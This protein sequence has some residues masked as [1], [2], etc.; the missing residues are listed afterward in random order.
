MDWRIAPSPSFC[1]HRASRSRW[2]GSTSFFNSLKIERV[3]GTRYD[4][5]AAAQA[6]L[7]DYIEPFYNR[8]RRHSTL[9]Y[10]SPTQFMNDW[11]SAQH[12]KKQ[13]A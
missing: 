10:R 8:R 11:I 4:A 1:R 7:F 3:H 13:V 6:N 9:G 5:L 2:S 12:E